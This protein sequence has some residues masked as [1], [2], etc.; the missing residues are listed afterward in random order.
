MLKIVEKQAE[1][2]ANEGSPTSRQRL[3]TAAAASC[4][5]GHSKWLASHR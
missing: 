4:E 1:R 5:A 3:R 2:E